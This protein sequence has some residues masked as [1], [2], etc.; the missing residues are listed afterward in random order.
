MKNY[1]VF[2]GSAYYPAGGMND[3]LKDFNTLIEAI[4]AIEQENIKRNN[5]D[6]SYAWAHVFSIKDKINVYEK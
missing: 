5:G 1:L 6:W 3:F 4:D 2:F